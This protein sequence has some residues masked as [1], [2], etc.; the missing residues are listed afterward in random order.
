MTTSSTISHLVTCARSLDVLSGIQQRTID[1]HDP[2]DW[3]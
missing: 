1:Q 3:L 2:R